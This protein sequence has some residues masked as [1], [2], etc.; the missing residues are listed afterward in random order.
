MQ[1]VLLSEVAGSSE[2]ANL[3]RRNDS[4]AEKAA[5]EKHMRT[6]GGSGE[7]GVGTQCCSSRKPFEDGIALPSKIL[8]CAA[9]R[10]VA[11]TIHGK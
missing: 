9:I 8:C 11:D 5:Q 7:S 10:P 1:A 3:M 4:Y 6:T 2:L